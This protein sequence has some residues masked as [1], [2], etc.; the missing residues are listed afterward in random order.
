M[1]APT[2]TR[3]FTQNRVAQLE[4]LRIGVNYRRTQYASGRYQRLTPA[5]GPHT[6]LKLATRGFERFP[7][8]SVAV[9]DTR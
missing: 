7:A 1:H 4:A 6:T 2:T 3:E 8:A 9:T 5:R